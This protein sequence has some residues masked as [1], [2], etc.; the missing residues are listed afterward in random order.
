MNARPRLTLA[1]NTAEGTLQLVLGTCP[2]LTESVP[3]AAPKRRSR[4]KTGILCAQEWRLPSQGAELLAPLLRDSCARIGSKIHDIHQIACVNGPG[5]F[6]GLRLA[7]ASAS[8]LARSTGAAQTGLA[9]LPLLADNALAMLGH[10]SPCLFAQATSVPAYTPENM[11]VF[12]VITHAR[13]NLV[14]MQ[15]FQAQAS[16]NPALAVKVSPTPVTEIAVVTVEDAAKAI[17]CLYAATPT[18]PVLLGSGVTR[19]APALSTALAG[20]AVQ[21]LFAGPLFDSPSAETLFHAAQQASY[22]RDDIA[23]AYVRP[24]DAEENLEHIAGLLHIDAADARNALALKTQAAPKPDGLYSANNTHCEGQTRHAT[25]E[26][27]APAVEAPSTPTA[28]G[29]GVA[30]SEKNVFPRLGTKGN[31]HGPTQECPLKSR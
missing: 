12:W 15:A 8:G 13:Q 27:T 24:C 6:T 16:R 19:N 23:P 1:L 20:Y 2:E 25:H 7:L 4:Q 9:Y 28:I 11:P 5:S 29:L 31:A 18:L 3:E 22:G 14:H 17:A 10:C 21:P 30:F 26:V